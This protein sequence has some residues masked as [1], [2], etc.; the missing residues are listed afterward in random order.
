MASDDQMRRRAPGLLMF[1]V[2][3]LVFVILCTALLAIIELGARWVEL[4]W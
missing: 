2:F 1:L 3:I 4:F